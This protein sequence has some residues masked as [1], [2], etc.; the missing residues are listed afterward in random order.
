MTS[1]ASADERRAQI[2]EAAVG[3]FAEKG[4]SARMDDI[5]RASGLSKGALYFHFANKDEIFLGLF[6]A[7]DA[8]MMAEW[9]RLDALPPLDAL[10]SQ[11]EVAL[12]QLLEIRAF[13]TVW[14]EFFRHPTA[15]ARMA[16]LYRSV[17]GRLA[18]TIERGI[19]AG[20]IQPVDA[21]G[22]AAALTALVEGLLLQALVDPDFDAHPGWNAGWGAIGV[23][24][25]V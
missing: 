18:A 13:G 23:Q 6:E 17:R 16:A 22:V 10:R 15:R 9:D 4:L 24:L 7:Y 12:A 3:C 2:L 5:V 25:G 14:V 11:G 19:E 8:R 21:L 1:H 20:S